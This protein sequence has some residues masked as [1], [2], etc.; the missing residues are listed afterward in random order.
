LVLGRKVLGSIPVKCTCIKLFYFTLKV[1]LPSFTSHLKLKKYFASGNTLH[2][3]DTAAKII[4]IRAGNSAA[5]AQRIFEKITTSSSASSGLSDKEVPLHAPLFYSLSQDLCTVNH[6]LR[7]SR[8]EQTLSL[9][10]HDNHLSSV[11][12]C[13]S[14]AACNA[15]EQGCGC[16]YEKVVILSKS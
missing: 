6:I 11:F 7:V 4:T 9:P 16:C 8:S 12:P 3:H 15:K 5:M 1:S 2:L 14:G 13:T 10:V